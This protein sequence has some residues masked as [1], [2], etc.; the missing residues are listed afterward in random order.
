MQRVNPTKLPSRSERRFRKHCATWWEK[1]LEKDPARALSDGARFGGGSGDGS[2]GRRPWKTSAVSVA[3]A[4]NRKW[5]PVAR[6]CDSRNSGAG[7]RN[8]L[9][10]LLRKV[11][12][13]N[14]EI[15]P[16]EG[17]AF[18]AFE[19][20][21]HDVMNISPDGKSIAFVGTVDGRNQIWIR[22]TKL[23]FVAGT[24]R[25][26]EMGTRRLVAR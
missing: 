1:S 14:Y 23:R 8:I 2:C 15:L 7:W 10:G 4:E 26:R 12:A 6:G 25:D 5:L 17:G 24:G 3:Q 18:A 11:R 16:P 21:D 19:T 22:E 13:V 20:P 9:P